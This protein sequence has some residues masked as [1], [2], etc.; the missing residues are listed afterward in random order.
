MNKQSST[1][2]TT[3]KQE[4]KTRRKE[5]VEMERDGDRGGGGSQKKRTINKISNEK[6]ITIDTYITREHVIE[7]ND[8]R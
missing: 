1:E 6:G 3:N 2:L 7:L 8:K 4:E 5:E